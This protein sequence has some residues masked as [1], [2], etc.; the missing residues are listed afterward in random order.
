[1]EKLRPITFNQEKPKEEILKPSGDDQIKWLYNYIKNYPEHD[2][3]KIVMLLIEDA[4]YG[5][6]VEF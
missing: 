1:M 3:A 2:S 6:S 4:K 5:Y